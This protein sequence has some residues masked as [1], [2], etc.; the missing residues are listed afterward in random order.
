MLARAAL[1][2]VA[3]GCLLSL[4]SS[5]QSRSRAHRRKH[6]GELIHGRN[7]RL[8]Q[9]HASL[10]RLRRALRRPSRIQ[11]S[12]LSCASMHCP[13]TSSNAV[14]PAS[15]CSQPLCRQMS[16]KSFQESGA[17]QAEQDH[18]NSSARK[19]WAICSL[20]ARKYPASTPLTSQRSCNS[21]GW[22]QR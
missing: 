6:L 17:D 18:L 15:N 16:R 4:A 11:Y 8:V 7:R 22:L 2:L 19:K 9:G 5:G 14:G 1:H 3:A 21:G 12:S 10:G 13:Y 20:Q